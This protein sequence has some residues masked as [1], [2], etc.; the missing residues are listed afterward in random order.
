MQAN[1]I[2]ISGNTARPSRTRLLVEAITAETAR[3]TDGRS[4]VFDLA[5]IKVDLVRAQSSRELK[6]AAAG[7]VDA[8]LAADALVVAS[9]VYKASYT[10]LFKHLFDLI[11]P[12]A[13][14]GK[15]LIMAAT[16]GSERH[17]LVL[18]HQF[19]P[20]FSFFGAAI[21]PTTIYATEND[22]SAVAGLSPALTERVNRASL[23]LRQFIWDRR[24]T[25]AFLEVA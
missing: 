9:P 14:I 23:Q 10:G 11:D 25:P 8:L 5:E 6:G 21:V 1:I 3:L 15:P 19:Q 12:K 7:V 2:G 20:L 18:E 17:A 16:G 24:R 22:L 4:A 13:L